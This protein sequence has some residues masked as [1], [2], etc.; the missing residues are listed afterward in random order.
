MR[1]GFTLIEVLISVLLGSLIFYY[2]YS[3]INTTSKNHEVYSKKS[4]DIFDSGQVLLQLYYDLQH[5]IGNIAIVNGKNYDSV[6][7]YTKYSLYNLRNPY[8]TYFISKKD[9][10]LVRVESKASFDVLN[11]GND[12]QQTLPY[13]FGDVLSNDTHSFRL[14]F[15]ENARTINIMFQ[16]KNSDML[17]FRVFKEKV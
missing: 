6:R 9:L 7:F 4:A 1:R 8:V 16:K 17:L 14:Y 12:T 13:M 2:S 11:I 5:S 10:A 15:D 3:T